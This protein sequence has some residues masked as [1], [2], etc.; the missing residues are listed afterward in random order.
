[1][2]DHFIFSVKLIQQ[3]TDLTMKYSIFI[4][5]ASLMILFGG[6]SCSKGKSYSELLRE[7]EKA[8]N[9]YLSNQRVETSIPSDSILKTGPD[10]PY[11]R[12]DDDGNIYMQVIELGDTTDMVAIGDIVYF[13]FTRWNIK[14]MYQGETVAGAGNADDLVSSLGPTSFVYG[15]YQVS[16]SAAYGSGIQAPLRFVGNNSEVNLVLKSYYGFS[17]DQSECLPY[18]INVKYFKAQY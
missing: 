8:C 1:M 13:R 12:I 2:I 10:A 9:W 3:N 4:F 14:W 18:L 17:S 5:F 16:S 11:Y 7:E 6:V 15:N